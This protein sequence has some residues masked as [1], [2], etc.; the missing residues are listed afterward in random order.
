M[1]LRIKDLNIDSTK[2]FKYEGVKDNN[3]NDSIFGML[4]D[5][6][7]KEHQQFLK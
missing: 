4:I 1:N 6:Q 5:L 2:R 7:T 3:V